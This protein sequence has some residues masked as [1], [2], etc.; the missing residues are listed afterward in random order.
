MNSSISNFSSDERSS[1][2][3]MKK[4]CHVHV[5]LKKKYHCIFDQLID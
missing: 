2:M 5:V 1:G 3:D 4:Q